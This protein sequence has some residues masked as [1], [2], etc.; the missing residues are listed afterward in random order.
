VLVTR[1]IAPNCGITLKT[2]TFLPS[3][4]ILRKSLANPPRPPRKNEFLGCLGNKRTSDWGKLQHCVSPSNGRGKPRKT[5]RRNYS[6]LPCMAEIKHASPNYCVSTERSV[7]YM[8]ERKIEETTRRLRVLSLRSH[9]KGCCWS[10]NGKDTGR[11]NMLRR[12]NS[13]GIA[14]SENKKYALCAVSFLLP[15]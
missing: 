11:I 12:L 13:S 15:G 4:D 2:L 6:F 10:G 9:T 14:E 1:N 7:G 8:M 3:V 5:A